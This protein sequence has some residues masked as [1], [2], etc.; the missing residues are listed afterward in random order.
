MGGAG[1]ARSAAIP[2]T[3][4]A[5]EPAV[6]DDPAM[7]EVAKTQYT[8]DNCDQAAPGFTGR[9]GETYI[10]WRQANS[11]ALTKYE[12]TPGFQ[13]AV[14]AGRTK[15]RNNIVPSSIALQDFAKNC[16]TQFLPAMKNAVRK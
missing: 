6:D 13:R 16:E 8:F 14:E 7:L 9:N 12:A 11:A 3:P 1:S 10:L 4:V 2:A 5:A 15:F